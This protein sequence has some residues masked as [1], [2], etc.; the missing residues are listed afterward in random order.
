[1]DNDIRND[2]GIDE[3]INEIVKAER[4]QKAAPEVLEQVKTDLKRELN[5]QI[6]REAIRALNAEQAKQ[7]GDLCDKPDTTVEEFQQFM[8]NSGIDL[9]RIAV[10]T[11]LKFREYYLGAGN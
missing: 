8:V 7:F 3:F 2:T 11:M 10:D 1:M 9:K 4:F 6:N 5:D